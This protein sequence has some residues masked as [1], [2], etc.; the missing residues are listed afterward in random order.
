MEGRRG[1]GWADT[2]GLTSG[3]PLLDTVLSEGQR[4]PSC[5]RGERQ[6]RG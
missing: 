1:R 2:L 4:H 5:V 3:I 6:V